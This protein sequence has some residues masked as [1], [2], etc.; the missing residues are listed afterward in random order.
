M[1]TGDP[2][3]V[4]GSERPRPV[5]AV[6]LDTDGVLLDSARLHARAWKRAFDGCLPSWSTARRPQP[7]FDAEREYR[8]LVDGRPRYDGARAFLAAR[9]LDLPPGSP[10]DPPGCG[11]V[12]AVAARKE[13]AFTELV[14][15]AGVPA[16]PEVAAVLAELRAR[17][18]RR[19]AVSASRHARDLLTAAGLHTLLDRI[20]D[21]ADAARLGLPGKPDP[22]LFLLAA[23]RLGAAPG[24]AAV[25]EDALAGVEAG[26]RGG[27][28]LVV[29]VD[30]AGTATAALHERGADLVVPDLA[31]LPAALLGGTG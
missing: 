30:R 22:A 9:G 29:G 11:G 2:A 1:T 26:T 10:D 23:D 3:S 18:V 31:G 24:A 28:A 25:V 17:G 15:D 27:F 16:Y 8:A 7:P 21:G 14:R 20:V 19:A 12:W 6:V 13:R 4:T 5:T